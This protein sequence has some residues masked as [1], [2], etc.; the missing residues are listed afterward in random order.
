MQA[1]SFL[2]ELE[3]VTTKFKINPAIALKI[4]S[5][6]VPL[7]YLEAE[8][9]LNSF[10]F[11]SGFSLRTLTTHMTAGKGRA[12][13]FIPLY[14]FQQN[15]QTFICNFACEMTITYFKSHRLYLS[16]CYSMRFTTLSNY[17]LIDDVMLNFVCLLDDL[18]LSYCYRNSDTRNR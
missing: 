15:I 5:I 13:S 6:I 8:R 3:A 16:D 12:P 14:H 1:G 10:F 7:L 4:I 17:H 11:L 18:I 2:A 9:H